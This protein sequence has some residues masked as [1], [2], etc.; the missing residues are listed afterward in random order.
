M[1]VLKQLY[2]QLTGSEP[3]EIVEF[4]ASG[5]NRFYFRLIGDKST[6]IGV[7][8]TSV[9]ENKAFLY[10][11]S[12]FA[13]HGLPVPRVFIQ[14]EDG[15]YYIQE[16]LGDKLLFDYISEGRKTGVFCEQE[17]IML[18]KTMR[19]L[20]HFQIEGAKDFDFSVCYPQ[21]EFNQIGRAHV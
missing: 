1:S 3:H 4:A 7:Q 13:G 18:R 20:A 9:D 14:S 16:D 2:K 11:S 10:M 17:K 19:K 12:H 6:L 5:S 21:P 8:G 15:M